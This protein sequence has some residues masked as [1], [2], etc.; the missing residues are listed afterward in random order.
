VLFITHDLSLV[1]GVADRVVVLYAGRV[2]ESAATSEL[3]DTPRH[4]YTR[5][6]LESSPRMRGGRG[7]LPA[8]PG[9]PPA[10]GALPSGCAFHPRC[11]YAVPQCRVDVPPSVAAPDGRTVACFRAD[12]LPVFGGAQ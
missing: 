3:F 6:L 8:I 11:M 12:E 10:L 5:G 2:V 4:P 9:Q 7:V 1:R